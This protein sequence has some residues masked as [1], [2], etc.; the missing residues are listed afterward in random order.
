MAVTTNITVCWSS[1]MHALWKQMFLRHHT[2]QILIN[3]IT[4]FCLSISDMFYKGT[5]SAQ[6]KKL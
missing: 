4:D 5:V 3:F 1:T 2:A 6:G